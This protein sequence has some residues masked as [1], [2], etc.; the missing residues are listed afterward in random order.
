ML[1]KNT[2]FYVAWFSFIYLINSLIA[3]H[4]SD[5]W[6]MIQLPANA[7]FLEYERE[8]KQ[9]ENYII[10]EQKFSSALFSTFSWHRWTINRP[11][12]AEIE[13]HFR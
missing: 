3:E 4:L 5:W 12:R 13:S 11:S 6:A 8:Q 1:S 9:K 7:L 2:P 10:Y